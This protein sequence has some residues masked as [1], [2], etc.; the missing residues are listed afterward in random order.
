VVQQHE[1]QQ[2][3]RLLVVGDRVQ[4]PGQADR[5]GGQVD[6]AGVALVEHE[7]EHPQHRDQR[8]GL[9]ERD[10]LTVRLARLIRWAIVASG[11]RYASAICRVVSPPTARSVSATADAG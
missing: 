8:A 6:V 9:V 4:P 10:P 1:R 7:V 5:L 11:T 2:P 3:G